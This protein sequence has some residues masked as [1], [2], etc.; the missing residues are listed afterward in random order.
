M[1]IAASIILCSF[2]GITGIALDRVF[3]ATSEQAVQDRLEVHLH[4]LI[5]VAEVMEGG[6]IE[7][8]FPLSEPRFFAKRSGL[9]AKIFANDGRVVWRSTSMADMSI[10]FSQLLARGETV[11]RYMTN[12]DGESLLIYG[13]G[14]AWDDGEDFQDGHTFAVAESLGDFNHQIAVF[15]NYLWGW[16][17]AVTV[18]LLF[19]LAIILRWGLS[20]LRQV[21]DDLNK[22]EAGQASELLGDYPRELQ[23]LTRN[24]NDLIRSNREHEERYQVSLGNLAHSLK[25]PLAVLRGAVAMPSTLAALNLT[26]EEQVERMDQIVQYQ[27]QRAAYAGQTALTAP[28]E[29]GPLLQK[30]VNALRKVYADRAV[31]CHVFVQPQLV[32]R[33]DEGDMMEMLGNLLDNAF[34]WAESAVEVHLKLNNTGD[35]LLIDVRDDGPG[36]AADDIERVLARGGRIDSATPGHGLGLAMVRGIVDLYRGQLLIEGA[37]MGG[38]RVLVS[39]PCQRTG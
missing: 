23:G 15:R 25:T 1:L 18:V 29:V 39:L 4:A 37:V 36:I 31:I 9:Y 35:L 27:L 5:A 30:V 13:L 22:I 10:P 24:L 21:A 19:V 38:A 6:A 14:I 17:A 33:C 7:L 11:F 26:V 32:Y 16:L 12:S 28:V 3:I 20:P 2:L 8:S 34:K